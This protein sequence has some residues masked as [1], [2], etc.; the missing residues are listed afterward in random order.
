MKNTILFYKISELYTDR[1]WSALHCWTH[2]M[3][4]KRQNYCKLHEVCVCVVWCYC[5]R[6]LHMPSSSRMYNLFPTYTPIHLVAMPFCEQNNHTLHNLLYHLVFSGR[7][8]DRYWIH[9]NNNHA[10][11]MW[12]CNKNKFCIASEA[13][14]MYTVHVHTH[15]YEHISQLKM[16][17]CDVD[18][19]CCLLLHQCFILRF[20]V[21]CRDRD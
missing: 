11:V 16:D 4:R 1:R 9:N 10:N 18:G 19:G 21:S 6:L 20:D 3:P 12:E 2:R 13:K 17:K 15:T 8:L 7:K 14:A 5:S